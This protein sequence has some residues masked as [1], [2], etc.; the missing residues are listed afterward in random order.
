M[1]D[2][3]G[4]V[5]AITGGAS[6]I[7]L[8][9]AKALIAR[10]GSVVIGDL[11][12]ERLDAT[13]AELGESALAVGCDVSDQAQVEAFAE[14]AFDW[15]GQV[16]F[17][18]A[19]AGVGGPRGRLWEVDVA[20]ARRHFDVNFWGAWL[21]CRAFAPR[22]AAQQT[23][24]VL[25]CTASENAF[26]S[27]SKRTAAYVAAKHAVLG[28]TEN[29]REDLPTHVAVGTLIPGWVDTPIGPHEFM[30]HGMEAGAFA[31]A[32]VPQMLA[33]ER[34]V[35]AH[36]YMQVRIHERID[37]LD[38]AFARNAPRYEGDDEHD[39]RLALKRIRAS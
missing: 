20:D 22:L 29:L 27:A 26:F 24:S 16:D 17:V 7:G 2:F 38:D 11:P 13:A 5:A 12:G 8:A 37:A 4:K 34:F 9:V 31:E 19:N 25:Y 3:A 23:P 21:T 15:H 36:P 30:R 14:T 1:A 35:V 33:G 39:V 28:M 6:G 10:G 32:I 18:L